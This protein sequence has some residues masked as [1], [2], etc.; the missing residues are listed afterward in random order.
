MDSKA[1]A[2]ANRL[3]WNQVHPIHRETRPYDPAQAFTDP[4]FLAL[5]ERLRTL[6]VRGKKVAQLCCNNGREL[7]SLI[8]LGA[9]G[10]TGYDICDE[11]VQEAQELA[12]ML[13][14]PVDFVRTD[15]L[16]LDPATQPPHDAVLLTI[17]ALA[18]IAD[19]ERLFTI[20]RG[21]LVPGGSLYIHEQ[22]PVGSV[23][24][25]L[26]E[27]VYDPVHPAKPVYSYF[28]KEPLVSTDGLDYYGNT[29]YKAL[30]AMEIF[31][32]MGEIVTAIAGAG[33]RILK[34]E[35]YPADISNSLPDLARQGM[36]PLSWFLEAVST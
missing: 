13:A 29:A 19:L 34:L 26:G 36:L 30:P 1:I 35:E 3:A 31:H 24:A 4:E 14:C 12:R 22:H 9:A 11:A 6:P 27:P 7:L 16:E 20:A 8:R 2:A 25:C 33:F 10:G 28:R 5:D 15:I 18:W 32:T 23:F 17:G 21:L